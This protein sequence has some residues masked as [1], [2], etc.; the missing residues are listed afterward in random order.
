MNEYDGNYP[1]YPMYF[2]PRP[3]RQFDPKYLND[4]L[5]QLLFKTQGQQQ[6]LDAFTPGGSGGSSASAQGQGGASY[7]DQLLAQQQ[8]AQAPAQ[9]P[10]AQ[11]AAPLQQLLEEETRKKRNMMMDGGGMIDRGGYGG[12]G[13]SGY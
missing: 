2:G 5:I 6:I 11:A 13:M 7:L 10:A 9:A 1:Q 3:S 8:Q 12:L 4:A